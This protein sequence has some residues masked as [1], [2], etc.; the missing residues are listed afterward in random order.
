[1][2]RPP[3]RSTL[4]PYTT[5]FR[6]GDRQVEH[7]VAQP[8]PAGEVLAQRRVVGQHQDAGVIVAEAELGGRADHALRHP[9]VGLAGADLESA[10][11]HGPGQRQR[12]QVTDRE[13][14]RAADDVPVLAVARLN[15]A[16][17]DRLAEP[18]QLLDLADL[19]DDHAGDVVPGRLDGLDLEADRGQP[20][21]YLTG[22]LLPDGPVRTVWQVQ[23][24]VLQQP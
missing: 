19:G 7:P 5:L 6:S 12:H 10:R 2:I 3:P 20:G 13:V 18:G 23:V 1:M 4:F 9:A 15:P 22:S 8:G 11:Q 14:D 21:G 24:G 16:V 17:P